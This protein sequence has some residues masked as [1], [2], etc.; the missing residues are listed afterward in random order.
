LGESDGLQVGRV[1]ADEN[2][3]RICEASAGAGAESDIEKCAVNMFIF[4]IFD[5]DFDIEFDTEFDT[6]I[7]QSISSHFGER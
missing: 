5:T 6:D 2:K 7:S 1:S 4:A 3:Y